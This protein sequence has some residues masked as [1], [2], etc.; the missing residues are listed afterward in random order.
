MR[1]TQCADGPL[2]A[3]GTETERV[4]CD[5]TAPVTTLLRDRWGRRE[6]KERRTTAGGSEGSWGGVRECS[7][8]GLGTDKPKG[9]LSYCASFLW[10]FW[11]GLGEE[12]GGESG[13]TALV[14]QRRPFFLIERRLQRKPR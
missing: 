2:G 4:G 10:P 14:V 13:K 7:G 8:G 1:G 3:G 6:S 9:L 5:F 12:G 11:R